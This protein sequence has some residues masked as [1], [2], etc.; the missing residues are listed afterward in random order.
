MPSLL[1]PPIRFCVQIADAT[2]AKL[3]EASSAAAAAETQLSESLPTSE[4][5]CSNH[6]ETLAKAP[7]IAQRFVELDAQLLD[8]YT[9]A[10]RSSRGRGCVTALKLFTAP[11]AA[12]L[13][14]LSRL[15][16]V[17]PEIVELHG[18]TAAGSSDLQALSQG[19][20]LQSNIL[21]S[22]KYAD[23]LHFFGQTQVIHLN[24]PAAQQQAFADVT[25]AS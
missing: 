17:D 16:S 4:A 21:P 11:K 25:I 18:S 5:G 3:L 19:R 13:G 22:D 15:G 24:A 2:I 10:A 1:V 9:M 8:L 23:L 7:Q 6:H 14:S 12:L 20:T